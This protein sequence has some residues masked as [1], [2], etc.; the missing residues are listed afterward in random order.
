MFNIGGSELILILLIAF[1]V[2]GPKDL[3]KIG[4]ALGRGVKYARG[5]LR[6]IK[7]ET[8]LDEVD[9]MVKDIRRDLSDITGAADLSGEL[10]EARKAMDMEGDLKD[11]RREIGKTLKDAG[12]SVQSEIENGGK[13]A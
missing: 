3:P 13:Q 7:K 1:L 12:D 4:R 2:V 5:I 10:R 8:G 9:G 6:E 11:I